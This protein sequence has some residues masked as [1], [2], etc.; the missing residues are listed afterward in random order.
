V[1]R[2]SSRFSAQPVLVSQPQDSG[3]TLEMAERSW[4][5]KSATGT[6]NLMSASTLTSRSK[7]GTRSAHPPSSGLPAQYAAQT[8]LH[9]SSPRSSHSCVSQGA[10]SSAKVF[11]F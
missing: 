10:P 3:S 7:V 5:S 2:P 11:S 6:W 4:P 8:W 1:V 9:F